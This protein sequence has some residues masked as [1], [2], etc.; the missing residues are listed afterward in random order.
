M[1]ITITKQQYMERVEHNTITFHTQLSENRFDP[2]EY[3]LATNLKREVS[4]PTLLMNVHDIYAAA[5]IGAL[6]IPSMS[7]TDA[8]LLEDGVFKHV[9]LKT[10][11]INISSIWKTVNNVLHTGTQNIRNK[12]RSVMSQ[13]RATFTISKNTSKETMLDTYFIC[14]DGSTGSPICAHKLEADSISNLLSSKTSGKKSIS[15]WSFIRHGKEVSTCVDK[16]GYKNWYAQ[17][18][19]NVPLLEFGETF[20]GS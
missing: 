1:E 20:S 15:L 9:E 3:H 19:D 17:T 7:G 4:I 12:K 18:V 14:I 5:I 2:S 11:Y 13:F 6:A 10:S 8:I 16:I